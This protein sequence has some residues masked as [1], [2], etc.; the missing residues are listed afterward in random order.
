ML[1]AF[2]IGNTNIVV[3]GFEGDTLAFEFRLR[4][5]AR[6][7]VDEYSGLLHSLF[8]KEM[9]EKYSFSGAVVSS[10]VPPLTGDIVKVLKTS[11]SLDPLIVGP[12][13]KTGVALKV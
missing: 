1:L 2:D 8:S 7:T 13:I 9:G 5:D 12:G 3:G 10:V 11:L 6:R 4:S